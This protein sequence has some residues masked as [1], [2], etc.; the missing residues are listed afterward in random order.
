[1]LLRKSWKNPFAGEVSRPTHGICRVYYLLRKPVPTSAIAEVELTGTRGRG[2]TKR[3][4]KSC[5]WSLKT[6]YRQ[7]GRSIDSPNITP[8]SSNP[9][10]VVKSPSNNVQI[11]K[12]SHCPVLTTFRVITLQY[13]RLC[14]HY[15]RSIV[16]GFS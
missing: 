10:I 13:C 9:V 14:C 15:T 6:Q 1:M 2:G 16:L 5:R 8:P 12:V 11:I 3:L 7:F 4:V